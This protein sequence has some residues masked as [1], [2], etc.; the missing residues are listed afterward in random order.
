MQNKKKNAAMAKAKAML[1][2]ANEAAAAGNT[3][4]ATDFRAQAISLVEGFAHQ[5]QVFYESN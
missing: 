4:L 5:S 1:Q 3:A 2:T